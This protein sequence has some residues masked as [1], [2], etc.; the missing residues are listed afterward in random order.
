MVKNSNDENYELVS[1]GDLKQRPEH[2]PENQ[3]PISLNP[4]RVP[5]ELHDLIPLAERWG[6]PDDT[7]RDILIESASRDEQLE[8]KARVRAANELLDN[9]LAGPEAFSDNPSFEY[10]VFSAM[11][12]A[13]DAI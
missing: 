5:P 6:N 2:R 8:L 12:M 1:I 10:V 7:V 13:A 11:R 9:W 3:P 4:T